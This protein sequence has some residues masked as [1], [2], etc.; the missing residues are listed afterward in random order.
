[1]SQENV[2]MVRQVF[3]DSGPL[4]DAAHISPGAEFDFTDV[5][6]DQPVLRGIE[7]MRQF[8]DGGPWGRSIRFVPE[9]YFDVDEDR[10]LV[11]VRATSTGQTSGVAV[12]SSI[13]H[14]LTIRGG[15]IVR[16]KVYRDRAK[17]LQAM[18]L[19]E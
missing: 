14:E 12:E 8:R 17:A 13:A 19:A 1:M 15:L 2:E 16:V 4:T 7:E 5:Y 11:F 9:R 6:P 3:L 18:G 10:V